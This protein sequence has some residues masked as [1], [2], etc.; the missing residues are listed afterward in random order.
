MGYRLVPGRVEPV[1]LRPER[2]QAELRQRRRQL[3]GHGA[4]RADQVAMVTGSIKI[5]EYGKQR[6][7]HA[8]GRLLHHQGTV[9]IDPL[10]VVGELGAE[11][12]QVASSAPSGDG[13]TAGSPV[14][15][16]TITSGVPSSG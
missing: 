1:A 8:A 10:A 5:I 4:E 16:I 6:G 11:P 9:P 13:G 7:Q 14:G 3:L 12:L 2:R 15:S